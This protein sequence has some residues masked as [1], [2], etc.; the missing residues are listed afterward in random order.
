LR[1]AGTEE[2]YRSFFKLR[3]NFSLVSRFTRGTGRRIMVEGGGGVGDDEE[4][5]GIA[6]DAGGRVPFGYGQ[7]YGMNSASKNKA[8]AWGFIKF[9]LGEEMQLSTGMTTASVLPIN[10]RA[11]K[12]K[13]EMIFS[14]AFMGREVPLDA[15]LKAGL[16]TYIAVTEALSDRINYFPV[17]DT[18]VN[19]MIKA[20]MSYFFNGSRT[21]AEVAAVLQNKVDLYLNE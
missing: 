13:A 10:N 3:G 6:A 11:R 12:Q 1:Q 18:T 7:G 4:I 16:E 20:E 9:L 8:L 17:R 19:D 15:G 5:A 2:K 21:A 14:G